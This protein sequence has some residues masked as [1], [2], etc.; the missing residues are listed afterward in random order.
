MKLVM[1][2]VNANHQTAVERILEA[3][4]VTGYTELPQVLGKGTSGRKLGSRAHPGS[5]ALYF[6]VVDAAASKALYTDLE[7]LDAE[8][9]P[10]E[11]LTVFSLNAEMVV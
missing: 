1:M 9:G 6:T 10:E 4:Q 8:S 2:V 11:G 7:R 3:H 5:S